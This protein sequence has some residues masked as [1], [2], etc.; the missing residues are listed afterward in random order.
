MPTFSATCSRNVTSPYDY[1]RLKDEIKEK[2]SQQREHRS[3]W[4]NPKSSF[5]KGIQIVDSG[6]V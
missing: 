4:L 5:R 3:I 2:S 1:S 6:L